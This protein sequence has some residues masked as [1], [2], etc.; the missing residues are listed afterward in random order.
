MHREWELD[1]GNAVQQGMNALGE[2]QQC[3]AGFQLQV[4]ILFRAL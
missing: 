1:I 3:L 4:V 2:K